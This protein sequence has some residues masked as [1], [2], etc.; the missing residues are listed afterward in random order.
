M[1][2]SDVLSTLPDGAVRLAATALCPNAAFRMRES[3]W[4][5]QF[6]PEVSVGSFAHWVG[7]NQSL[8]SETR[9]RLIEEVRSERPAITD[10][11]KTI[12]RRFSEKVRETA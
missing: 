2:L 12:A 9:T 3:A 11:A 8:T 10:F 1:M 5:I 4:G 6:H 7:H